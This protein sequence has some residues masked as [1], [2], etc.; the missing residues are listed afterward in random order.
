MKFLIIVLLAVPALSV[1]QTS[2]GAHRCEDLSPTTASG[3]A[4][5]HG[6][7]CPGDLIFEDN[8]DTFNHEVWHHENTLAGSG[9][10]RFYFFISNINSK[11]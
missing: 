8:F 5:P 4:A 10:S 3:S 9:V 11:C 2:N 6:P 7:F 1:I